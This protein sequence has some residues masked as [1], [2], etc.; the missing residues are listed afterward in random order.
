MEAEVPPDPMESAC[1]AATAHST[2]DRGT[3]STL[4]GM[5]RYTVSEVAA[6]RAGIPIVCDFGDA[7]DTPA[8]RI[9]GYRRL[10]ADAYVGRERTE[11]GIRFRF[12]ADD[13][14]EARVRELAARE[15]RCCGFFSFTI[16]LTGDEV[17]WETTVPD[18]DAARAVLDEWFDLPNTV[19]DDPSALHER[20]TGRGLAFAGADR[21]L[22]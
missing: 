21:R 14:I 8:E 2:F 19:H 20:F 11:T 18:D 5:A 15:T 3:T 1:G 9:E 6:Q 22:S 13:G 10:F 17:L 7:P 4:A 12:R 16:T